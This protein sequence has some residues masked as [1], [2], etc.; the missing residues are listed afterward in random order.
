MTSRLR[1]PA[2][3]PR[4]GDLA[5][6][7][8][9]G[10]VMLALCLA[11]LVAG[12]TSA[13]VAISAAAT[14]SD[15]TWARGA[16]LPSGALASY[17]DRTR[18]V[19]YLGNF[20]AWGLA[21]QG[22]RTRDKASLRTAWAHLVWYANAEDSS[23]FV[24]DYVVNA[25]ATLSST[26]DMDSTDSYAGT[27]LLAAD[28]A[29]TAS[30]NVDG[31]SAARTRLTGLAAGLDGALRAIE[32][33]TDTDGLTWA[34][35]SWHVKYLMDQAEVYAGLQAAAR[36]FTRLGDRARSARASTGAQHLAVGVAGLWNPSASAYDWAAHDGG[37]R[38]RADLSV[39]Y[40]DAM[41]QVWAVSF[42][43]VPQSRATSLL[44]RIKALH[45]ELASPDAT[46]PDGSPVGY[47]P[48][49]AAAW[50]A[51]GDRAEADRLLTAI[52]SGSAT[53]GRPWP[54]SSANAGQIMVVAGRL[55]P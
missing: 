33:T 16:A 41:E 20:A 4:A 50:L 15:A 52:D 36:L 39:L 12:P 17:V 44:A 13:A 45:P 8:A 2:R 40:P 48:W 53:A 43:L 49:A 32:A 31:T 19:P 7:T 10:L 23:G 26:G 51:V 30:A 1:V 35:P 9:A 21:V 18:V 46:S 29:Y 55:G 3:V 14:T 37:G 47:W 24:T 38:A 25:D 22:G 28:A 34:K 5:H 6:S 54:F 42:G 27:F 11:M